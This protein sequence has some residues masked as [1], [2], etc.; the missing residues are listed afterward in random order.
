MMLPAHTPDWVKDAV[1]YQIFPDRFASSPLVPKP[2]NLQPWG[3]APTPHGFQGGDLIGAADRL[4]Y[5]LD[6]G[7]NAI[8]VNPVFAS[9][10]NHRYHTYDYFNVDPILGGNAAL[11]HF[12]A[13]AHRRHMRVI[14]DG[15]FN[16]ASR[17]FFQFNHLMEAGAESPYV[18]WWHVNGWPLNAYEPDSEPNYAAWWGKHALP[19][20]N[21][22]N[23]A[24]RRFLWDVATHWLKVGIDGW[25]LDVPGEIDDDEFW[26][27]FRRLCKAINPEAYI[28][29]ELWEEAPRWLQGD[30]FDG[31]MNYLFARAALGFFAGDEL[32]Q[33]G[34]QRT[35]YGRLPR[36]DG[37]QFG[38]ALTR[39]FS[40]L[41]HPEIV[42]AQ[43]N[44]V[45]SHD[46]PRLMTVVGDDPESVRLILRCLMTVPGAPNIYYGDEIGMAGGPD[47]GCRRAFP[48]DTPEAWNNE[49][50][51]DVRRL[52]TLRHSTPA[53][54][55]GDFR[56]IYA[57]QQ[58]LMYQRSLGREVAIV[59]FN[60]GKEAHVVAEPAL[61]ES[62]APL[63]DVWSI[64]QVQQT[65]DGGLAL[66]PRS[67]RLWLSG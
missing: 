65:A 54:R 31:Q 37:L 4:D 62:L 41:Y 1:F 42:L 29:G 13:E 26:R 45:G 12:L 16:H 57:A 61:A 10:A 51:G 66:A 15:V 27:E 30:M 35:G 59:A 34:A 52:I 6:L 40:E 19:K 47:P 9:G 25:R 50:L 56:L 14:L 49:L 21:T 17:G 11:A 53:L 22:D 48:W 36:L 24:V 20:F 7:I 28:V 5:L 3:S 8:F 23:P 39:I 44:M 43:L 63:A 46:T 64:G 18:N 60:A 2:D 32:D 67:S 33:A 38:A 55:R 58:C